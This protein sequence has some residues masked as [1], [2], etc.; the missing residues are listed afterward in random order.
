MDVQGGLRVGLTDP[1]SLMHQQTSGMGAVLF[2]P[3][4][5][6]ELTLPR[7]R[8]AKLWIIYRDTL[9]MQAHARTRT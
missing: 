5:L 2:F 4:G 1:L 8:W 9:C 6:E 7:G 3:V